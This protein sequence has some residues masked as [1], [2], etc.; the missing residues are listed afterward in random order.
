MERLLTAAEMRETEKA[1]MESGETSGRHLME[2]AGEGAVAAILSEW[3][4]LA[5]GPH[6]AAVL[7]GPGN[8]GGDG[9]VVARLLADRGW[10]VEVYLYGDP[11]RVAGDARANLEAWTARHPLQPM[12]QAA[13][14][15]PPDLLIDAMFGI[16]VSRPIPDL[17]MQ[18]WHALAAS[19]APSGP[20]GRTVALDCP[21]GFDVDR[22]GYFLPEPEG[23]D[24]AAWRLLPDL[25][26]TFHAAKQGL[27]L[28]EAARRPPRVVAIGLAEHAAAT[29][30]ATRL[31]SGDAAEQ[32]AWYRR[33]TGG[34]E[35][36]HK[37]D[38]GHALVLGGGPGKGG[39]AR[40]A[41]RAALRAGAGL[42]TVAVPRDALPENAAQL[43]AIML[44]AMDTPDDLDRLLEDGRLSAVCLG[45]GLGVGART[46][47]L[48][49]SALDGDRRVV[50]DADALTSFREAPETLFEMLNGDCV[51][52]PHEGEFARL[53]PDLAERGR[54]LSK[55][56]A[57][58][59]AAARCGAVVLLKGAATVIADPEGTVGVHA[60]LYD[61]RVPQLAT[62]GAGD[63]LAGF[64]T[65]LCAA[66]GRDTRAV[67]ELAAWLHAES[68]RTFG[69]GLIAEDLPDELPKV[70]AALGA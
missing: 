23:N 10:T 1:A 47:E 19:D 41:A 50:L 31:L 32:R 43:N 14:A 68:A 67:T 24:P 63:V 66:P 17:C 55:I 9:F 51:L 34:D 2:R 21:S 7:C 56:D 39:A 33:V 29:G 62:A 44:S 52:T 64:I 57:A 35:H 49:R 70:L 20:P 45:P 16:G 12:E 40:M 48:V 25:C 5:G 61:R 69:P 46:R 3:P 60:A 54:S 13:G 65:G 27:F 6:R 4:D 28:D 8:N 26:V 11:D 22:G 15:T 38:R 36:L 53:F 37:Y 58:R 18:A 42:V 30:A 59:Q